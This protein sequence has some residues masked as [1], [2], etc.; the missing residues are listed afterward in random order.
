VAFLQIHDDSDRSSA[1]LARSVRITK[2]N[3]GPD[4][5]VHGGRLIQDLAAALGSVKKALPQR[6]SP[7]EAGLSHKPKLAF[8]PVYLAS[9][10]LRK[11]KASLTGSCVGV[12]RWEQ[13]SKH[14]VADAK[15]IA[16]QQPT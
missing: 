12:S 2:S 9:V 4:E 1:N 10:L 8:R 6:K 3:F 15:A 16:G 14:A 11:F 5:K 13:L 7:A